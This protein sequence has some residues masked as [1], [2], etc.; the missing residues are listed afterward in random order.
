M[1]N[2]YGDD[3]WEIF[4]TLTRQNLK[5]AEENGKTYLQIPEEDFQRQMRKYSQIAAELLDEIRKPCEKNKELAERLHV[6][7]SILSAATSDKSDRKLTRDL[8]MSSLLSLSKVPTVDQV[9]HKLME[10]MVPGLYAETAFVE[11]NR[12]NWVLYQVL[13]YAKGSEKCPMENWQ[14]YANAMLKE[15]KMDPLI[16]GAEEYELP[17]EER[18]K[19]EAWRTRIGSIGFVDFTLERRR[20]L[21]NYR[22]KNG[23]D[24]HGGKRRAIE[25]VSMES[26]IPEATVESVFGTLSNRNSNVHPEVLIPVMAVMGCTLT[27]VN[28]MLL[29][30]NRELVYYASRNEVAL[31]W[32]GRLVKN[33]QK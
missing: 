20:H 25:K 12:R 8:V 10:L 24:R 4:E 21:Q 27:E 7:Q 32:I 18:A 14:N 31:K 1:R 30:A 6:N 22:I 9:N 5:I 16:C 17:E 13:E 23:L 33:S 19:A 3:T 28:K 15:L 26:G 2:G 29:Q 11:E